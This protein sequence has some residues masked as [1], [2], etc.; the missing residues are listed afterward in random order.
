MSRANIEYIRRA[1]GEAGA[2][3]GR[4][5]EVERNSPG[6]GKTRYYAAV[7]DPANGAHYREVF[8]GL[9]ISEAEAFAK[10]VDWVIDLLDSD[11]VIHEHI[12]PRVR[13]FWNQ[14]NAEK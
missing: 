14:W 3:A 2:I 5:T 11:P 12:Y 4:T 8:M 9:G 10:G 1:I 13:A 6:D 7:V